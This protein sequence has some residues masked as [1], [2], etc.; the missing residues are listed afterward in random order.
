MGLFG[1][2][3]K[4]AEEQA[5]TEAVEQVEAEKSTKK[6]KA[7]KPKKR[8]RSERLDSVI[9]ETVVDQVMVDVREN[10]LFDF[11]LGDQLWHVALLLDTNDIGGL[12]K[13][14]CRDED[15]GSLVEYITSGRIKIIATPQLLEADCLVI[16][17]DMQSIDAA[18]EFT[19]L[20][21]TSFT[22]VYISDDGSYI[23]TQ[24][25]DDDPEVCITL[26]DVWDILIDDDIAIDD[27][28]AI[29]NLLAMN[30]VTWA[31]DL[32][33][34]DPDADAEFYDDSIYGTPDGVDAEADDPIDL[35]D[36]DD[37]DDVDEPLRSDPSETVQASA[38]ASTQAPN[39]P[40]VDEPSDPLADMMQAAGQAPAPTPAP[41][42][43]EQTPSAVAPA[44]QPVQQPQQVQHASMPPQQAGRAAAQAA[45]AVAATPARE[46]SRDEVERVILN[47]FK[48]EDLGLEISTE[49]FDTRFASQISFIGFPETK[50]NGASNGFLNDQL[51]ALRRMAN[52]KL[53][54]EHRLN[55]D[56]LRA[57]Y[58]AGLEQGVKDITLKLVYDGNDPDSRWCQGYADIKRQRAERDA[59]I[60]KNAELVKA[61]LD[62]G[63]DVALESYAKRAY[64][65][66]KIE[67]RERYGSEHLHQIMSVQ[68]GLMNDSLAMFSDEVDQF[69]AERRHSAQEMFNALDSA[70]MCKMADRWKE[71]SD[72]EREM[73]NGFA[74]QMR[75]FIDKN[76][77][78]DIAYSQALAESLA[79]ENK[80]ARMAEERDRE[81]AHIRAEAASE[82]KRLTAELEASA[83][84]RER[85]L[86][87]RERAHTVTIERMTAER[88]D[89][90]ARAN[91]LLD[92]VTEA[93]HEG[94][95]EAANHIKSLESQLSD[96]KA[97]LE[98][99]QAHER[100]VSWIT[101]T[102]IVVIAV[103]ACC[104]GLLFGINHGAALTGA[105]ST[106]LM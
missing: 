43:S 60:A 84:E 20:N 86:A 79:R 82:V 94:E 55:I 104:V 98:D 9:K 58:I 37:D 42:A 103:C 31:A 50:L 91:A 19:L 68:Q 96:A 93:R 10:R 3:K 81:I 21:R 2:K 48:N 65:Q 101:I 44:P 28:P 45:R 14:T 80:V 51:A 85:V 52:D 33:G 97:H 47:T 17:P 27:A 83:R 12:S 35:D 78:D 11:K 77:K 72:S 49:H 1:K 25:H 89:L 41:V 7:E 54:A 40:V 106:M 53:R 88:A 29:L 59:E 75:D 64:E 39:P 90:E 92:R 15:K 46:V 66:A 105:L 32:V 74:R 69:M 95:A 57:E 4:K 38:Q 36:D 62:T 99:M 73:F 34:F 13:K 63:F 24:I 8:K 5:G 71:V 56:K 87:E 26:A 102:L 76:R 16:I 67:Y 6:A 100:H 18:R 61:Q 22:V 30:G 23:S 70:L